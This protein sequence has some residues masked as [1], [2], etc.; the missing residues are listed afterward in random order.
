MYWSKRS[1]LNLC[2]LRWTCFSVHQILNCF[3]EIDQFGWAD[4]SVVTRMALSTAN[5]HTQNGLDQHQ[6]RQTSHLKVKN[7]ELH[8]Y[9]NSRN[10]S[11]RKSR[12]RQLD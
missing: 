1:Q 6:E 12:K 9:K 10:F 11:S 3:Y 2:I 5:R 8:L 7:S 4:F